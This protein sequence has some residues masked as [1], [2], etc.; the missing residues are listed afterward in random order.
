[1]RNNRGHFKTWQELNLLFA[2]F[3]INSCIYLMKSERYEGV[4]MI[5]SSNW[6]QKFI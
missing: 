6:D 4:F 3:S 2:F 1:V 5:L